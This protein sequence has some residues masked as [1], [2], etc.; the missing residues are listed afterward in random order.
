M[1]RPA[2]P[3]PV[4][5]PMPTEPLSPGARAWLAGCI[6]HR[7]VPRR[8]PERSIHIDGKP[9]KAVLHSGGS[10]TLVQPSVI[11]PRSESK[12]A[13]PI[14][15]VHGD[16]RHV[17][18]RRVIIAA[19]PG[20]W[21]VEVG[22]VKDLPVPVLLGRDWPGFEELLATSVQSNQNTRGCRRCRTTR[23]RVVSQLC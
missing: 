10:I 16:T 14:T 12:A 3:Q 4:D 18:A 5:E 7:A 17:P 2:A 23:W 22:I 11:R 15:C 13:V 21:Q 20:T 6:V 9:I 8:A 19:N 1:S